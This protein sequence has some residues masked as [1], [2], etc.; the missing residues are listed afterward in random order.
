MIQLHLKL[1]AEDVHILE[2]H[3]KETLYKHSESQELSLNVT[4]KETATIEERKIAP[5]LLKALQRLTG[6]Y[7][8]RR[9]LQKNTEW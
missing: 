5:L 2:L 8:W 7:H 1:L 6:K 3:Y 4:C 9:S